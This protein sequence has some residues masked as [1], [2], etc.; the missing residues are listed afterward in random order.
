MDSQQYIYQEGQR[1]HVTAMTHQDMLKLDVD[2][3]DQTMN[4]KK[5]K[6][7]KKICSQTSNLKQ[8]LPLETTCAWTMVEEDDE[9]EFR[10][11]F[12]NFLCGIALDIS[13]SGFTG[14]D[15]IGS[16]FLGSMF[17][18]CTTRPIWVRKS[19]GHITLS[20]PNGKDNYA[21][22]WGNHITRR[23]KNKKKKTVEM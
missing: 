12:V 11:Y 21:F 15:Q 2:L 8:C 23:K 6:F 3:G 13:L 20:K 10:Q 18:H 14:S 19:D 5:D 17:E 4:V 22:A 9:Y 1:K 16:T 7:M